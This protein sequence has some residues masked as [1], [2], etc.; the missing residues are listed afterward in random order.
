MT[1]KE[2]GDT[3]VYEKDYK[4]FNCGKTEFD[5]HK[6]LVFITKVG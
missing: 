5:N 6:E 1:L 3:E 4:A 2:R